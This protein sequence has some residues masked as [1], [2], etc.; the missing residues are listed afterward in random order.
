MG[1]TELIGNAVAVSMIGLLMGPVYPIMVGHTSKILP[2]FVL[3]AALGLING[4]GQTGSASPP[5]MTG[6]LANKVGMTNLQPLCV[7]PFPI[8]S[9]S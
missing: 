9:R 1:R 2:R 6:I 7:P 5:F 8:S 4:L 3:N